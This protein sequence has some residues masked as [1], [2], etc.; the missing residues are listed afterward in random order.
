M[1]ESTCDFH[2]LNY[3]LN[4]NITWI[5]KLQ[6]WQTCDKCRK[7]LCNFRQKLNLNLKLGIKLNIKYE[8][9]GI[10]LTIVKYKDGFRK[11]HARSTLI[12]SFINSVWHLYNGLRVFILLCKYTKSTPMLQD[13]LKRICSVVKGEF[14]CGHERYP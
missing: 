10:R 7:E 9:R 4:L 3:N 8:I 11:S 14:T 5:T 1:V 6:S 12:P 2:L 13:S